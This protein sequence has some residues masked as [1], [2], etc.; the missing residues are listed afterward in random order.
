MKSIKGKLIWTDCDE[1]KVILAFSEASIMRC[2]AC[3]FV[4]RSTLCSFLKVSIIY[5]TITLSKSSPPKCVSPAVDNTSKTSWPTSKIETSKVPPPKSKIKTV[6]FFFLS[7]PY[8]KAAAVGSFKILK[9]F[10]P[11]IV[12]ASFVASLWESLK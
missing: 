10:K 4:Y 11:A 6:S 5:L 2:K 9:T 8:A 12:P 3:F 1:D 7:R